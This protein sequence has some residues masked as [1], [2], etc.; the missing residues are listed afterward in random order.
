[1]VADC[2]GQSRHLVN[3]LDR[4]IKIEQDEFLAGGNLSHHFLVA[5]IAHRAVIVGL[6]VG[7]DAIDHLALLA[8]VN[9]NGVLLPVD[10]LTAVLVHGLV[11]FSVDFHVTFQL[12]RMIVGARV[13]IPRIINPF[14]S[15]TNERNVLMLL[16]CHLGHP[17]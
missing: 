16:R 12:E 6:A 8:Q 7:H 11:H 1:M 17:Q 2:G 14:H 3:E 13:S 10:L 15:F 5:V 9:R 4:I